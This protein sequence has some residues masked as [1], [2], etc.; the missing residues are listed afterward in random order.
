VKL[1]LAVALG[2]ASAL[3]WA[4]PARADDVDAQLR[5]YYGGERLSAYLVGG[6]G[7]AAAGAG[8]YLVTRDAPLDRGLGVA[9]LAMGSLETIGAVVY[10]IQVG[11]EIRHY[12]AELARD[13]GAY[14]ADEVEH[15][16]GTS[17]RFVVYRAV[18]LSLALAG[19]GAAVYGAASHRPQWTGAGIGVGSLAL[20]FFVLDTVN[21]AR[22]SRYL[23]EVKRYQPTVGLAPGDAQRPWMLSVSG[24]F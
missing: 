12:E 15:L 3:A 1:A 10:A 6:T 16:H 11:G 21:D 9:W 23:D 24:R 19:A 20:P 22:A 5:G 17:S 7:A 2:A 8:A 4:S 14:R 18:E 13:P